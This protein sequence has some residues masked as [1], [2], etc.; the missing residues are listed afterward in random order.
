MD[1][2]F[3]CLLLA[4]LLAV[5]LQALNAA[6]P[7]EDRVFNGAVQA[8][9]DGFWNW[10]ESAFDEFTRS[11][12]DSDRLQEVILYQAQA[13]YQMGRHADAI[14]LLSAREER[15]GR[16]RDEYLYWI[17][18]AH[19]Q[20]TNYAAAAD[21]FAL[22]AG[23]FPGSTRLLDAAVGEAAARTRLGQTSRVVR[24]MRDPNGAFLKALPGT[25]ATNEL[26]VDGSLRG[27]E[28]RCELGD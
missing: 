12:P 18:Q 10:A 14:E 7:A 4:L 13:R 9:R 6:T 5:P 24:I 17:A 23:T 21:G 28:G 27:G 26:V 3:R 22:L 25:T 16:W 1:R 15:A 11:F 8:F 19:A 2:W 20:T